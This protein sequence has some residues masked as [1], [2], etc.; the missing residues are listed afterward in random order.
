MFPRYGGQNTPRTKEQVELPNQATGTESKQ[1]FMEF[2]LLPLPDVREISLCE[3]KALRCGHPGVCSNQSE[4][5]VCS[6][7][8]V[9]NSCQ[10]EESAAGS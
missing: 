8:Y 3:D 10:I 1:G 4:V 6:V 2:A 5:S 9:K 7:V